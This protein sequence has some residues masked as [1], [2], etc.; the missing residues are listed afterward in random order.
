MKTAGSASAPLRLFSPA[1]IPNAI[2]I[3][4]MALVWPLVSAL[5]D[6]QASLALLLIIIAGLSDGVDGF[7]AK[8]CRWQSR[9]GGW[10]D[11]LAD[12]LLLIAIFVTLAH[13]GAVPVALTA[14]IIVRDAIVVA[15]GIA[16]QLVV[17]P[18][19]PAPT[20][21]SK[22]NTVIQLLF[23]VVVIAG[24]GPLASPQALVDAL[25]AAVFVLSAV[26]GID[27]VLCWGRKALHPAAR[28]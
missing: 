13:I 28:N 16:Y 7:L 27:Y 4:R 5:L 1:Q 18:L 10:L 2:S 21:A 11:P 6:G 12:K 15:G 14:M 8:R 3:L 20:V 23:V 26:S 19:Q 9:L 22:A 25:G 17:A 24:L